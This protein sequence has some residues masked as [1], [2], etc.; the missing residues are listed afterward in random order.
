MK[1]HLIISED[2]YSIQGEGFC[3]GHPA[4]FLRLSGCNLDCDFCDSKHLW[5]IGKKYSFAQILD[6]WEKNGW[7]DHLQSNAHLVITGG[8]PLL[9]QDSLW[10]F[11]QQFDE[12]IKMQ[13]YIELET[14]ATI[15]LNN[16]FL[17]RI[18]QINASPKLVN[19]KVLLQLAKLNKTKFKF[20]IKEKNDIDE[21][22]N[23]Y[24]KPFKIK[25]QNI[26]LMPEG[27][28]KEAI[29]EKSAMV[30]ELCKKHILNFSPRLQ[31]NM[32]IK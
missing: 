17:K 10:L 6:N 2:F 30:I 22:L 27:K 9:Q 3:S 21:I 25:R 4:V 31:V 19:D 15:L 7:L 20:V 18:N 23:N 14:N 5:T 1:N 32:G 26:C 13:A 24:V 11:I 29:Q 12:T 28:T 8:E 16:N